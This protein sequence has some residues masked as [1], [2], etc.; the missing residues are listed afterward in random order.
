MTDEQ[1]STKTCTTCQRITPLAGFARDPRASDGR[2]SSCK[3]CCRAYREKNHARIS[4]KKKE[5]T[6]KN[7]ENVRNY[8]RSY[9]RKNSK[10]IKQG[11]RIRYE[12]HRDAD[13]AKKRISYEQ[14]KASNIARVRAYQKAQPEKIKAIAAKRRARALQAQ[15]SCTAGQ[16]RAKIAFHR[17]TSHDTGAEPP[18]FIAVRSAR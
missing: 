3:E 8:R 10:H 6:S 9:N 13:L 11:Q 4:T 17:K 12:L 7:K 18:L 15:G 5:W 2:Q 16:W 14:N 1:V